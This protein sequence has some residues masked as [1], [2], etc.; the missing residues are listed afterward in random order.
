MEQSFNL[1]EHYPDRW[2]GLRE[3]QAICDTDVTPYT[4]EDGTVHDMH[5]LQHLYECMEQELNNSLIIPYDNTGGAD[6]YTVSR[7]E[8]MLGITPDSEAT[9]ADRIFVINIRLFQT[10]PYS[11]RKIQHLLDSLLGEGE[12]VVMRD[13][14]NKT[15]KVILDLS[16]RFKAGQMREMLDNTIPANMGLTIAIA[17]TTHNDMARHTHDDLSHYTHDEIVITEFTEL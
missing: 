17:Y 16:S 1:L 7:W 2:R 11:I 12:S 13:V 15:L 8:K 5:T 6:E 3:I 14:E 10:A 9:L 4:D